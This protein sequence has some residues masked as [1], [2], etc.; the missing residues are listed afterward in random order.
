MYDTTMVRQQIQITLAVRFFRTASGSEPVRE[1]LNALGQVE[2]RT[3]GEEI[4][5]VQLG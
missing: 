3:I 5:T 1:W 4:K 2:R